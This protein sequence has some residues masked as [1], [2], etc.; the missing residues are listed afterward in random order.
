MFWQMLQPPVLDIAHAYFGWFLKWIKERFY[1][2]YFRN[3]S[4]YL[5]PQNKLKFE[6]IWYLCCNICQKSRV[7]LFTLRFHWNF[8]NCS[9]IRIKTIKIILQC[10]WG[11]FKLHVLEEEIEDTKWVIR[12]CKSKKNRRHNG[13]TTIYKTLHIKLK[14]E[15]VL[16]SFMTHHGFVTILTLRGPLMEQ[17]LLTFPEHLSSPLVFSGV[18]DTRSLVLY[19]M[20]CRSLFSFSG[21]SRSTRKRYHWLRVEYTLF[22]IYIKVHQIER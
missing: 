4:L 1:F 16:S 14:I 15:Y 19:A 9:G 20:F 10:I 12:I 7:G 11:G 8:K 21:R 3:W 18:R 13:Q 5:F 22:V 17:Q 2:E 6:N